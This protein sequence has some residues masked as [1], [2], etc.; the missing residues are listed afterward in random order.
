MKILFICKHNRFRSKVAEALFR[1]YN[2]KR[3]AEVKS[4]GIRLD[5]T[6]PYIAENVKKILSEYGVNVI[7][8]K[9]RKINEF[10]LRW[11]DSIIIVA[12][13]VN[14]KIFPG[15]KVIVWKIK[16]ADENDLGSIK[17]IVKDI[18][19]RVKDLINTLDK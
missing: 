19:S 7:D 13:N 4:A 18:E 8:E 11:A 12:D 5:F 14:S 16:D 15:D 6:R 3:K 17:K 9:S 10:D 2:K 1:K